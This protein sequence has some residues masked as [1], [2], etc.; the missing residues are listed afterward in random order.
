[1]NFV[2]YE[3]L[4]VW[5]CQKWDFQNVNFWINWRFL[6][7]CVCWGFIFSCELWFCSDMRWMA[8]NFQ[9]GESCWSVWHDFIVFFMPS[10]TFLH[11]QQSETSPDDASKNIMTY[12][13]VCITICS[14]LNFKNKSNVICTFKRVFFLELPFPRNESKLTENLW[15]EVRILKQRFYEPHSRWMNDGRNLLNCLL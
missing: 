12:C 3:T 10:G 6:P 11:T 1:M 9:K 8:P 15:N 7:Q 13:A 5:I 4:K 2:K 14:N